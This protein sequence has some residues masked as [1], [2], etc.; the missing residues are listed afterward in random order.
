MESKSWNHQPLTVG[1]FLQMTHSFHLVS[2]TSFGSWDLWQCIAWSNLLPAE[3]WDLHLA[4]AAV[5]TAAER[6]LP[7]CH[8]VRGSNSQKTSC[9]QRPK[10]PLTGIRNRGLYQ[11]DGNRLACLWFMFLHRYWYPSKCAWVKLYS[12]CYLHV[13]QKWI[14]EE[15]WLRKCSAGF[16][17]CMPPHKFQ[18]GWCWH[19]PKHLG[20]GD[21]GGLIS[22]WI[23]YISII[24]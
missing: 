7:G 14:S 21:K 8:W 3:R 6:K 12:N 13:L 11:M 2:L 17:P 19:H 10:L 15:L 4:A 20:E 23:L 16:W 22:E 18:T 5:M 9:R 1:A 24:I